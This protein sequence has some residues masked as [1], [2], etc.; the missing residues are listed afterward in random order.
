MT[1]TPELAIVGEAARLEKLQSFDILDTPQESEFDAVVAL[2]QR[3]FAVPIAAVSLIDEHRQWF[4]ARC[5]LDASETPREVSFCTHALDADDLMVVEDATRDP[6]FSANPLV[7]GEAGIRFYAGVPLH[8]AAEG[9]AR[10]LPGLGTLCI[11]DTKPRSFSQED[12]ATLTQLAGLVTSLI[13]ARAIAAK[14]VRL[15]DQLSRHARDLDRQHVQLRQA[16]RIAGIGSWRFDIATQSVD[17]SDQVFAIYGLPPGPGPSLEE[18][19]AFFPIERRAEI[20][21][22][23]QRAASHAESF[24]FE[25]DFHTADGRT[26]RVR[27]MG[28]PELVDGRPVS[29]IGVFQ[30]ITNAH[31]REQALR[32]TADTDSLTGLPNR[33]CFEKQLLEALERVQQTPTPAYLLMLDLDG[34]KGVND[35]FGHAAGDDVLQLFAGRLRGLAYDNIFVARL[36][37]DEFAM[38][39]TRPRDCANMER[40]IATVLESLRHSVERDGKR[41][42]VSATI[43]ATFV[44]PTVSGTSELMR[45]ADLAL[46]QAKRHQR[47]SGRIYESDTMIYPSNVV[48]FAAA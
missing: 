41:R 5:G 42:S 14:A 31:A 25:S 26:R 40:V 18:A 17:W 46:Y 24:D 9:F 43:G 16:E 4:K 28:E 33:A 12:R 44:H 37:G 7:T 30:D 6:R 39:V 35:T 29:V 38:I 23:L 32:L 20:P 48:Q 19:M 34:F 36:G 27:S 3:L 22:L 15:S 8:P 2:A 45:R 1:H 13:S 10:D 21:E 11:V 47:G